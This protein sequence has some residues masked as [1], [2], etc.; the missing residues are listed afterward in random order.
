MRCGCE[1]AWGEF[2]SDECRYEAAIALLR[3]LVLEASWQTDA[4]KD[5]VKFLEDNPS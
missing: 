4:V 2:S 3:R 5:A 1:M